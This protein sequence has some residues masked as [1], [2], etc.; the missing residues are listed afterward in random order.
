MTQFSEVTFGL[1]GVRDL[2]TWHGV[3][4]HVLPRYSSE[5]RRMEFAP[6]YFERRG[7][8]SRSG[9]LAEPSRRFPSRRIKSALNATIDISPSP[10]I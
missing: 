10:Y 4:C 7:H 1:S 3:K 8:V 2:L 9:W 5:S 6:K